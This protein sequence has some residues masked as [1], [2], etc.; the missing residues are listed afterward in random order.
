MFNMNSKLESESILAK[1]YGLDDSV[2]CGYKTIGHKSISEGDDKIAELNNSSLLYGEFTPT[3][4]R[5][6]LDDSHL[7]AKSAKKAY[8]LGMGVG[9]ACLQM[10]LEYYNLID[11]IGVELSPSR[12]YVAELAATKLLEID[13]C[14]KLVSQEKG[15]NIIMLN[16]KSGCQLTLKCGN[17]FDEKDYVNA[18]FI[19]FDTNIIDSEYER[20]SNFFQKLKTGCRI[21]TYNDFHHCECISMFYY[22]SRISANYCEF[23][24]FDTSWNNSDGHYF[25]IFEKNSYNIDDE[26]DD[27]LPVP[28]NTPDLCSIDGTDNTIGE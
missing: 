14:V 23:D 15:K 28:P 25:N 2:E 4:L 7:K 12:F 20:I 21:I 13:S 24:T 5:R 16:S 8:D 1:I 11:I 26:I 19:I 6:A 27:S 18:D 9:K 10:F 3:G 22:F 17:M